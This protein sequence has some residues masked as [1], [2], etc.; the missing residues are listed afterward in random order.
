[1]SEKLMNKAELESTVRMYFKLI[2][3]S[4][5]YDGADRICFDIGGSRGM[6][7]VSES[8][9]YLWSGL[10]EEHDYALSVRIR[11]ADHL[12]DILAAIDL[13]VDAG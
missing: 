11:S 12:N 13:G 1:M 7:R 10:G 5:W 4:N 9:L 2:D 3:V 6:I 8:R